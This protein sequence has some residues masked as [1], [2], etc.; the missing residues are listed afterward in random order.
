MPIAE[1]VVA[2]LFS[3]VLVALAAID[4]GSHRI[5]NRIVLPAT[6]IALAV[7]IVLM[8]SRAAEFVLA[9]LLAGL[10][11]LVPNL[12]NSAWIGMGDVKLAALL[13]AT[14][15]WAVVGAL[16]L[17]FIAVLPV[18]LVVRVRRG[19]AAPVTLPFAPFL[20]FGALAVLIVPAVA[21]LG[22]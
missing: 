11:L 14:L 1:E 5:P 19:S 7:Q 17:A 9:A 13:G 3:A 10:A 20:A 22:G 4:I 6:A 15:G 21:G 16:E 8:P 12:V 18:A 2:G